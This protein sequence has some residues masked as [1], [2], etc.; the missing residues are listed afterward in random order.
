M[1]T[2][3]DLLF[4][5]RCPVC[6]RP[7]RPAG[8]QI[9]RECR[10]KLQYVRQPLCMKC[11]KPLN[12]RAEYCFD[13]AHKKHLYD[14]GVCLYQY[15][16][17]R[18]TVYRFKYAGRREYA[19]FLGG[20]MAAGLGKLLLSWKPDGL[21]PVPLHPARLRRRGYNQAALLAAEIG[22]CLEIPVYENWIV[23]CRNTKPQ[24]LL[25]GRARQNNLKRAFKIVQND[26]KLKTIIVIDD[27][28][29]TGS[30]VDEIAGLCRQNGV[31]KVY[32]AALSVGSGL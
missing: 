31:E 13:C 24:K 18:Q 2:G 25:D 3:I 15:G 4:P 17:V 22:R 10:P 28:Y 20:E 19:R 5:R 1:L 26:V 8:G 12:S 21:I 9:C 27:I 32:F 23:R 7:V 16:S 29:T 30:T 6:D 14:R 11:G